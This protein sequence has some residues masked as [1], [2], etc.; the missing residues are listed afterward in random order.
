MKKP[1][2]SCQATCE[3]IGKCIFQSLDSAAWEEIEQNAIFNTY[4][5]NAVIF[6]QGNLPNGIYCVQSGKIKI[7]LVNNEGKE[8]ISRIA[9][10]GSIIGHR[11]LF[12]GEVFHASAIALE[13]SIVVF[14][15]K[16]YILNLLKFR[17][18]VALQLLAQLSES[19]GASDVF[20]ANLVH[21][22][23]R[24][25]LAGL[26]IKLKEDYGIKENNHYRLN[27]KLTREEMAAM[28]G[29]THETLVRLITEFKNEEIIIQEG[30][31]LI[32]INEQKLIEFANV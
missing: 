11:A 7:V 14:F 30:K 1:D 25:R 12:S 19:V 31:N 24:E 27:I 9:G 20:S 22:N 6:L 17:P 29:T 28:I 18:V 10:P 13:D 2:H 16:D 21:K 26:L 15:H 4:K 23:V 5:K 8:S 3:G 32:I